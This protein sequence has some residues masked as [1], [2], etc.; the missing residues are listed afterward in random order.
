MKFKNLTPHQINIFNSDGTNQILV[1]PKPES[2]DLVARCETEQKKIGQAGDIP[3]FSIQYKDVIGLPP[4]EADTGL[5][6]SFLV[7][8][9]LPDR[10]DLYSPGE[11]IRDKKTGQPIGCKGLQK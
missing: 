9:A 2:P 4:K 10:G 1:L 11:L 5:V 7:R 8:Q 3:V 6:V